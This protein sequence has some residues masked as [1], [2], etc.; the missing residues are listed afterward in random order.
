MIATV[1]LNENA[2]RGDIAID[3]ITLFNGPCPDLSACEYPK[4]NQ[5]Q[6]N[7]AVKLAANVAIALG[8]TVRF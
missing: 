1:G 8:D 6:H 7:V 4:G 5:N 3:Q 2:H